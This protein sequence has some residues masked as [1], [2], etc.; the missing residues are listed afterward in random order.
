MQHEQ[1]ILQLIL[2]QLRYY[3][4]NINDKEDVENFRKTGIH[5]EI[6]KHE[7]KQMEFANWIRNMDMHSFLYTYFL[8]HRGVID[9]KKM[10]AI[11]K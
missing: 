11:K 4:L 8:N 5:N 1:I 3:N 7:A 2:M 10:N 9:R 6:Y